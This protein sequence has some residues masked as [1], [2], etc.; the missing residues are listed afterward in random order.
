MSTKAKA[1]AQGDGDAGPA[2][3]VSRLTALANAVENNPS[4]AV[5]QVLRDALDTIGGRFAVYSRLDASGKRLIRSDGWAVPA[6]F[7]AAGRAAGRIAYELCLR[8][9]RPGAVWLDPAGTPYQQSDPD[10]RRYKIKAFIGATVSRAGEPV[11]CL[12]IYDDRPRQ[13]LSWHGDYLSLVAN[14]VSQAGHRALDAE[15]TAREKRSAL[16]TLLATMAFMAQWKEGRSISRALDESQ[17]LNEQMLQLSPTAIYRLDIRANRF[18]MV[19]D[20]MCEATGYSEDELLKMNPESLLTPESRR[21][22]HERIVDMAAGKPVPSHVD[23]DVRTKSGRIEWVRFHVRHLYEG[24]T[25]WGANVVAHFITEQRKTEKE[26]ERYR[27]RLESLVQERTRELSLANEKLQEEIMR[28]R[29]TADALRLNTARLEEL[30]T[31]MRVLLDKR[32]EDRQQTED[33]IRVNLAQLI[34]PYLDRLGNSGLNA[35]Q[36]QYLDVIRM[37]IGEVLGAPMPEL[38]VKYYAFSPTELQVA[39]LIRKG[40]TTKDV[41]HMLNLSP[42]TVESYRDSIRRK[43]GLKNR[44]VNLR[45]FL[46]RSDPDGSY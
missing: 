40:R 17:A 27:K 28:G 5:R 10:I 36:K 38:S 41:A 39:N 46:S 35:T 15:R 1:G 37:N 21:K 31:A 23:W 2:A 33:N 4:D 7:P 25:L 9:A 11:G 44:K 16:N 19:N 8:R 42:R 20:Y 18:I 30:N 26:L 24:D 22:F 3:F 45:T 32:D 43:L 14:W 34:E 6:G 29:E 13:F 12:A